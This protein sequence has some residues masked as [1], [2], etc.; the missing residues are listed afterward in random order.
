[1]MK[2]LKIEKLDKKYV[3]AVHPFPI[4]EGEM[5]IFAT[6]KADQ[7]VKDL[8]TYRDYSLRKR[9]PTKEKKTD[10]MGQPKKS[11]ENDNWLQCLEIDL[12]MPMSKVDWR[13]FADVLNEV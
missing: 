9:L 13:N 2:T 7:D 4:I 5:L 10:S 1:M 11:T 12:K 6:R 3:L 8:I